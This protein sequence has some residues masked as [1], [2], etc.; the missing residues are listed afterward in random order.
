V[1]GELRANFTSKMGKEDR[2]KD[3]SKNSKGVAKRGLSRRSILKG[4]AATAGAVAFQL[5]ITTQTT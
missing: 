1:K 4:A 3:S 2:M 5:N